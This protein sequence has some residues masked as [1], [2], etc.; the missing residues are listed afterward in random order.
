MFDASKYR[1]A[2][3]RFA[4]VATG[5]EPK[6]VAVMADWHGMTNDA[7]NNGAGEAFVQ[8][9]REEVEALRPDLTVVAAHA[10]M[11]AEFHWGGY[12]VA[13]C[14]SSEVVDGELPQPTL[15][16]RL[17]HFSAFGAKEENCEFV[18]VVGVAE[19]NL[20]KER[21][22]KAREAKAH[23]RPL[24]D[25]ATRILQEAHSALTVYAAAQEPQSPHVARLLAELATQLTP[26]ED[27]DKPVEVRD[28]DRGIGTASRL[29]IMIALELGIPLAEIF[30]EA[31]HRAGATTAL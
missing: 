21:A 27:A 9:L 19:W 30:A 29:V 6:S 10:Q 14:P 2:A 26:S 20:R 15:N 22:A 25:R 7:A 24:K 31:E 11:A 3:A 5:G 16:M 13:V 4:A 28:P 23:D 18:S 17:Y 8:L 1:A 12:L